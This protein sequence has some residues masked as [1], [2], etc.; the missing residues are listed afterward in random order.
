METD[1]S[2]SI[3]R[4]AKQQKAEHGS[5]ANS[6]TKDQI[7]KIID[8]MRVKGKLV[9]VER[10]KKFY[11]KALYKTTGKDKHCQVDIT[12]LIGAKS[13]TKV[14]VHHVY[15]RYKNNYET[16]PKGLHISHL[17]AE[18]EVQHLTAESREMNESRKYCHLFGWYKRLPNEDK[19]RCPHWENPCT[20]PP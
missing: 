14:L 6:L 15:W 18:P 2:D 8:N 1:E 9:P 5:L 19:I 20:G 7:D 17:D 12:S 4:P 11:E 13:T 16:L 3:E 10:S